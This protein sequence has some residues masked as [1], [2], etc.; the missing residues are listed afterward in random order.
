MALS[1]FFQIKKLA[2]IPEFIGISFNSVV[3]IPIKPRRK[4]LK[5]SEVNQRRAYVTPHTPVDWKWKWS[6]R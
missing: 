2:N 1:C 3:V 6:K 5:F 4:Q